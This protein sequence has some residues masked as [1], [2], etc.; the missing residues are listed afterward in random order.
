MTALPSVSVV[1]PTRNR[2]QL[3]NRA[4]TSVKIQDIDNIEIIVVLDGPDETT[5]S[6]LSD[7]SDLALKV[8]ELPVHKG[9]EAA[10]N[11]GI[12]VARGKW[13][14][15][16][17]DD[18][19]WLPGKLKV[20]LQLAENSSHPLPVI[21]CRTIVRTPRGEYIAPRRNPSPGEHL[22][23]YLFVRHGIFHG[24]GM[25]MTSSILA[26]RDLFLRYPFEEQPHRLHETL[27]LLRVYAE[28]AI[29]PEIAREVL[30][31]WHADE[32]RPRRSL[33]KSDWAEMFSWIKENRRFFTPR[34]Y[35]QTSL[36]CPSKGAMQ[37]QV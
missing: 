32:D 19:E 8:I 29:Y 36:Y 12:A 16:L 13:I 33:G 17:D 15:L 23:D 28:E 25:V 27:W 20:Q 10:S 26:P 24:E 1:V 3:L 30:A 14:A 7:F 22:S 5:R 2:P 34:A 37:S 31:I 11:A 18:D 9:M 21:S 35:A 6:L 4:I